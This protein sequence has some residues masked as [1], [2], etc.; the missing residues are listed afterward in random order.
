MTDSDEVVVVGGGV[1]GLSAA[2]ELAPDHEV[3]LLEAGAVGDG[4]SGHAAG[5]VS[6][7][8]HWDP[9][10]AAVRASLTFFREFDGRHG[11]EFV[12]RPYVHLASSDTEAADLR[13]SHATLL[14]SDDSDVT[15][16]D[17]A[18]LD[19]R[20][21]GV[22]DR[23]VMVGG[24]VKPGGIIDPAAYVR[25]L[26][27]DACERGVEIREGTPVTGFH[28][29]GD[30]V[31]G[32]ETPDGTVAAAAVVVAAGADT[33][34]LV[35]PSV[36]LPVRRFVYHNARVTVDGDLP[37]GLPMAYAD[38]L[39]WRPEP[40][41]PGALLVSGGEHF[42]PESGEPPGSPPAGFHEELRETLARFVPDAVDPRVVP[43][44]DHTCPNGTA[45][46][47]DGLPVV[48]APPEAPD[49]L[50]VATGFTA[51]VSMSPLAGRLVRAVLTGEAAPAPPERFVLDRF[52][53]PAD[54]FA[55]PGIRKAPG[56]TGGV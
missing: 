38:G 25:A 22:F 9:F 33:A 8:A 47:P 34:G 46:T 52:D 36:D 27:V 26:A 40:R 48:D 3:T 56:E 7:F 55:V 1:V 29:D 4:A 10:E 17:G 53:A 41:L 19:A 18:A 20:W 51:G 11:F 44:S 13:D 42:L 50:V 21:P 54:D 35:A 14:A 2:R 49:G 43:G 37:D 30:R 24:L 16:L 23:S 12:E 39:W 28:V 32:I 31:A 5:F 45:I 15:F 6:A